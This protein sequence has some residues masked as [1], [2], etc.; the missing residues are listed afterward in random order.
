MFEVF[1]R[2]SCKAAKALGTKYYRLGSLRAIDSSLVDAT[3]S[4]EWADYHKTA[5]VGGELTEKTNKAKVHLCF[6][7]NF[8]IPRK[9]ILMFCPLYSSTPLSVEADTRSTDK[10][11]RRQRR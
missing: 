10:H 3:L 8:G 1:E 5:S 11:Y 7:I 9:I 2:L 4:M 6:D